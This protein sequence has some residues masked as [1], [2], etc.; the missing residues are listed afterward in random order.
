MH[1]MNIPVGL[2]ALER[3]VC[4][5]KRLR[6]G[7]VP[8]YVKAPRFPRDTFALYSLY[9]EHIHLSQITG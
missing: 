4:D 5:R 1:K 2:A 9:H 3:E 8:L 7:R 6:A